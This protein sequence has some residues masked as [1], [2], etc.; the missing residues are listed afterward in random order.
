MMGQWLMYSIVLITKQISNF[1]LCLH[2]NFE[3]HSDFLLDFTK[4]TI[5]QDPLSI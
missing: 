5:I 2:F 1:I 4:L 3:L